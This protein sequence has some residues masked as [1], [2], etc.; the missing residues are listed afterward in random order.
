MEQLL[1][2]IES[3]IIMIK[4]RLAVLLNLTEQPHRSRA[5]L[6]PTPLR[7]RLRHGVIKCHKTSIQG[8]QSA[9]RPS[10]SLTAPL[11]DSDRELRLCTLPKVSARVRGS[12]QPSP[13]LCNCGIRATTQAPPRQARL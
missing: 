4:P 8:G 11:H 6:G 10:A 12:D 1:L 7:L 5:Q 13:G 9:E 3:L 2:I